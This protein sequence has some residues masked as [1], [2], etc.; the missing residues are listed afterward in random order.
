MSHGGLGGGGKSWVE[1]GRIIGGCE[2]RWAVSRGGSG[3]CTRLRGSSG[4]VASHGG[5]Q[6]GMLRATSGRWMSCRV[7]RWAASHE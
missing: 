7:G 2:V 5:D 1:G 6:A 3:G 4:W